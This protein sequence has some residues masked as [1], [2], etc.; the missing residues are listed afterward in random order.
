LSAD[1]ASLRAAK[2]AASA[3]TVPTT[4]ILTKT[5]DVVDCIPISPQFPT[6]IAQLH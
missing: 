3:E 2:A 6:K 5:R 4:A 1:A